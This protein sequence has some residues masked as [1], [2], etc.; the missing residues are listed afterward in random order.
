MLIEIYKKSILSKN[1][2]FGK[3]PVVFSGTLRMNLDPFEEFDDMK[4]W[5]NLEK[6]NLKEF[7]EKTE[8]KLLFKCTEN[9]DN[10]RY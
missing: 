3:D 9:G 7:F 4:I 5:N 10:L 6:V 8:D 2:Y 1:I